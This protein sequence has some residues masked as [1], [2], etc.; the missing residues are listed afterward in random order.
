MFLKQGGVRGPERLQERCARV[1]IGRPRGPSTTAST[2]TPT[3][4]AEVLLFLQPLGPSRG[5]LH[6]KNRNFPLLW[7]ESGAANAN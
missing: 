2:G 5:T 7:Q 1:S 6:S 4:S 3:L